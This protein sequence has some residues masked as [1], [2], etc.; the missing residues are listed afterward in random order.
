MVT[1]YSNL[2]DNMVQSVRQATE[3]NLKLQQGLLQGWTRYW[4]GFTGRP[5][6]ETKPSENRFRNPWFEGMLRAAEVQREFLNQQYDASIASLNS[7]VDMGQ[8][9]PIPLPVAEPPVAA[10][11]KEPVRAEFPIERTEVPAEKAEPL[12]ERKDLPVYSAN[13]MKRPPP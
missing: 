10:S 13:A 11:S 1:K 5:V 12:P 8:V 7:V 4:P 9:D 6:V 3:A 2:A